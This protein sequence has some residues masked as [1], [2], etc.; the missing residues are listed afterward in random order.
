MSL[1][2]I[3]SPYDIFKGD[4]DNEKRE[5]I[6]FNNAYLALKCSEKGREI[7]RVI[8]TDPNDYLKNDLLPGRIYNGTN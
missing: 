7:E 2:T 6:K 8:S 5:T 1:H 3:I 4:D